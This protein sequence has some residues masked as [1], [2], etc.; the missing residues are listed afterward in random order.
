LTD[1]KDAGVGRLGNAMWARNVV[2]SDQL[3]LDELGAAWLGHGRPDTG[4]AMA[5]T[6]PGVNTNI[7]SPPTFLDEPSG[8]GAQRHPG[9]GHCGDCLIRIDHGNQSARQDRDGR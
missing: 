2:V 6:S 8:N 9:D 5:N 3:D 7:L 4:M 1:G